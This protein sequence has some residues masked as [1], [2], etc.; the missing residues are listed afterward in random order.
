MKF[1]HLLILAAAGLSCAAGSATAQALPHVATGTIERVTNFPSRYVDARNVD[2]WLPAGYSRA[3]RYNVL[4]MHDGQMLFD[5]ASTW[6]NQAWRVDQAVSGLV[7]QGRMPDTIVVGIWNNGR[8]RHAEY[9]PEKA[10]D[11]LAEPLRKDFIDRH[12]SG[13]ALADRYLRFIV[14]ELK[15]AID[16]KYA[17]MTDR[18][19]TFIMGSSMG[20]IISLYAMSE[21]PGIFGGAA[22]LSTHWIG[23]HQANADVPMAIFRYMQATL[24]APATHR[25]YMDRGTETLDALYRAPQEFAN[26]IVMD[27]GYASTNF[28]S[29]VFAGAAHTEND[30]SVRLKDVLSFLFEQKPAPVATPDDQGRQ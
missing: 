8:Y 20:G 6:N 22:C 30:W 27:K 2:V 9:F 28:S 17:T 13:K 21:Y 18:G 15:P 7:T 1:P 4:Y 26:Q 24:P 16:R 29:R 19:H 23:T 25:L 3:K 5:A 10:L 12:L 11:N 14:D